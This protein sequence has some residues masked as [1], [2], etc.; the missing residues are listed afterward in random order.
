[1][2]GIALKQ[3]RHHLWFHGAGTLGGESDIRLRKL[4]AREE[5]LDGEYEELWEPR[6]RAL[7]QSILCHCKGIPEAG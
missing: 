5:C 2:V 1:M 3:H 6:G 4:V 7:C